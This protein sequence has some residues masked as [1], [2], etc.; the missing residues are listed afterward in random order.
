MKTTPTS[1]QPYEFRKNQIEKHRIGMEKIVNGK[2]LTA[3]TIERDY[4]E[5]GEMKW[6]SRPT[7]TGAAQLVVIE[8]TLQ[9]GFGHNFHKHPNQEEVIYVLEGQVEQWLEDQKQ[10]LN[11]G[12][13]IFVNKD[14]V[15]ASF[16]SF[17]KPARLHVTLGPCLGE[18]GYALVDVANQEPWKSL[19]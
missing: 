5:W 17:D 6:Y 14:I 1:R 11:V 16:N 19:R 12:D 7:N 13:A 18:A 3:A 9:P 2:F 8:V 15:H 10:V 4:P